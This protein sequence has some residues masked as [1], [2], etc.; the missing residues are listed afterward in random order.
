MGKKSKHNLNNL[1]STKGKTY[2]GRTAE[3]EQVKGDT[4]LKEE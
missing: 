1:E 4:Q 2:L 3:M